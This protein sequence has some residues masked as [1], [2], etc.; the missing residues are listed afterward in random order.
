M[1]KRFTRRLASPAD[2]GH[3]L[4]WRGDESDKNQKMIP[5]RV[6]VWVETSH[7]IFEKNPGASLVLVPE[8]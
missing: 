8:Y 6:D 5:S 3:H 2:V 1:N 7:V 4:I